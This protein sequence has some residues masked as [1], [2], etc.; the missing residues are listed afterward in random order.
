M[1]TLKRIKAGHLIILF[2]LLRLYGITNPPLE[3][4]H[5][6][7]QATTNMYA[8]N[9]L[10]VDNNFLYAR[11]DMAGDLSPASLPRSFRFSTTPFT[12]LPGLLAG[13]TGTAGSS[14][15]SSLPSA[16]GSFTSF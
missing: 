7:R 5:N 12:S 13:S 14:T 15:S 11:V 2:F 8:R 3:R 6:W 16:S 4:N 10:E 9:F 1:K